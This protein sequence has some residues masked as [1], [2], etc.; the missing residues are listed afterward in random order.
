MRTIVFAAAIVAATAGSAVAD[1]NAEIEKTKS[2]WS[3]LKL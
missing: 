2:D 1:C 3:A